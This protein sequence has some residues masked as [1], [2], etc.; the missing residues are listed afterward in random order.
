MPY[1][2]LFIAIIAILGFVQFLIIDKQKLQNEQTEKQIEQ[3]FNA[4]H[5][6]KENYHTPIPRIG[7]G[8]VLDI[9]NKR[10]GIVSL[11]SGI[12]SIY[13]VTQLVSLNIEHK[14]NIV[15]TTS[16]KKGVNVGRAVIGGVL[17]GGVGAV[18][19]GVSGRTKEITVN[20]DIYVGSVI[21]LNTKQIYNPIIKVNLNIKDRAERVVAQINLMINN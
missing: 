9:E 17:F 12:L 13:D 6:D 11:P 18:I 5:F 16:S 21:T 20:N 15:Q 1:L 8:I 19:G 2:I 14:Y 3:Q 4:E 10:I 7:N